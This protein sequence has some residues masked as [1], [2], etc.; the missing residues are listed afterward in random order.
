MKQYLQSCKTQFWNDVFQVELDY[1]LRRLEGNRDVLS[2]GCGPAIIEAGL[3]EHG[4]KV[5]GLDISQEALDQAPDNVRTVRG[6]AD[7]MSFA[8][9]GFDAVIYIASLQFIERYEEAIRQTARVLPTGGKVLIMLLN[10]Q[11]DF[12]KKKAANP[13]SYVRNIRHINIEKIEKAVAEYFTVKTEY[14]LGIE[15]T[16]IFQ[17]EESSV[18]SLYVI[19]GACRARGGGKQ[20]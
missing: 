14:F 3:A 5:T 15:G 18:A 20:G 6:S 2:V 17:S 12:F 10:P 9:S 19:N 13:A 4:F 8:D 16:R 7:M 1:V 11:S